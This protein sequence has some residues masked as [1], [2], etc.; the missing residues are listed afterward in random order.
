MR[1]PSRE[2]PYHPVPVVDAVAFDCA[3]PVR[4]GQFWQS[5]LGGELRRDQYGDTELHGGRVRLDFARVPHEKVVKNRLHLDLHVPPDA[6]DRAIA[7]VLRL[8]RIHR[9]VG[10][11]ERVVTRECPCVAGRS[12]LLKVRFHRNEGHL[13]DATV[14]HAAGRSRGLR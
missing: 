13:V 12:D 2:A 3:D 8:A 9:W 11:R 14:S 7:N 4:L 1:D 5:L 6:K 10:R